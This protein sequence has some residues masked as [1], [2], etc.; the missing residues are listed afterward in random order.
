MDTP[1]FICKEANREQQTPSEGLLCYPDAGADLGTTKRSTRRSGLGSVPDAP[2]GALLKRSQKNEL[3]VRQGSK[4]PGGWDLPP[5]KRRVPIDY[6]MIP[7]AWELIRQRTQFDCNYE[8]CISCTDETDSGPCCGCIS[9]DQK[10]GYQDIPFCEDCDPP[11]GSW[12]GDIGIIPEKRGLDLPAF[13]FSFISK[14]YDK[15]NDSRPETKDPQK[16]VSGKATRSGKK[17]SVCGNPYTGAAPYKYPA[18]PANQAFPW[19]GIENGIWD[20]ISRYWGNGSADC[21]DWSVAKLQ[22]ADRVHIGGGT[23]VRAN[24]QSEFDLPSQ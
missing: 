23:I 24:Y 10:H 7:L 9:M 20:S 18:F 4:R 21:A 17:V 19:D 13:P 15:R 22:P 5:G 1:V 12:P 14:I 11:D 2:V 6:G 3:K 16:H 8:G